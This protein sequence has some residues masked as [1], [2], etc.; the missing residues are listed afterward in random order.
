MSKIIRMPVYTIQKSTGLLRIPDDVDTT[1]EQALHAACMEAMERSDVQLL[2]DSVYIEDAAEAVDYE[3]I[4]SGQYRIIKDITAKSIGDP[5][6]TP[7]FIHC[8]TWKRNNRSTSNDY[9]HRRNIYQKESAN[10]TYCA[11]NLMVDDEQVGAGVWRDGWAPTALAR[12]KAVVQPLPNAELLFFGDYF[13]IQDAAY[14]LSPMSH[15]CECRDDCFVVSLATPCTEDEPYELLGYWSNG[16]IHGIEV[17]K[18]S[19]MDEL[20]GGIPC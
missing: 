15:V 10:L 5:L 13:P 2:D 1:N 6:T 11:V 16:V 14:R 18:K 19:Y 8:D 12:L 9:R 3:H 17:V 4:I 7:G 20:R